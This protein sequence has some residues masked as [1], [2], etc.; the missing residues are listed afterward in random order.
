MNLLEMLN[1]VLSQSSFL[2]KSSFSASADIDDQ[3][4]MSIANKTAYEIMNFYHWMELRKPWEIAL[5]NGVPK[6]PLPA[7]YQ[8]WVPDSSWETDGSRKVDVPVNNAEWY[9]YK[10]SS[11]TSAGIIRARIYGG[12]IEVIEPFTGGSIQLEYISK[13]PIQSE[14]GEYKELFTADTDTF[15]MDDQ[16]LILGIQGYW[17]QAKQ[18]PTYGEH[19]A[20][21]MIKMN[22]AIGRTT[23]G[24]TIGG[25][26]MVSRRSPYTKLWV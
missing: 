12:F 9:Q 10:F 11:L 14:D 26:P 4:M 15:L 23:G 22:E 20:N 8:S 13:W 6:Y 16:L 25:A 17:Q 1:Q 24:Q 5:T 2:K 7:D 3:Q 18:M 21:Y 19:I